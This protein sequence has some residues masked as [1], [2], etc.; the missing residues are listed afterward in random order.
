MSSVKEALASQIRIDKTHLWLDSKTEVCWIKGSK[1][2]KQFV[3]NRVNEI[4]SLTEESMWNHCPGIENRADVGCRGESAAKLKSNVLW[5]KGPSWLS[6]PMRNWHSSEECSETIAEECCVEMKK[7]QA[8]EAVREAVLLTTNGIPNM[9]TI[10]PI[11]DFSS[12]DKLFRI[13]ALVLPFVK[14]LKIKAKLL[15]IGTVYLGDVTAEELGNAEMKWL[16]SV[17]NELKSQA[18]YSQLELDFGLYEDSS[19]QFVKRTLASCTVCRR[20]EGKSYRVPPQ[21]DLPEFRLS[22]KPAFTY[23]GIDYA[24]PLYIKVSGQSAL[25]KV[26]VLLFTCCSVRS[27]H[28]EL[29]TDLSVDVFIRCLRRFAARRGLPELIISDNAKTFK[30]AD[31]ILSKLFSYP[32]VKKFLA[33]KRI[34]WRFDVDKAPLWG[35]FFERLIHN[36]KRCLRK[37]LRNAKLNY[38]ELH[39]ALVEVEGTLNSR[40]EP[41]TPSHLMY[42]R[43]I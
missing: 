2:W 41:L 21:S 34:D 37:T 38:D 36:T 13:T 5:W 29:A 9:D 18:N 20:Y 22:Q 27:V 19:G 31:K 32:R 1:E 42:G 14:N 40:E 33:S 35:G 43:R 6:K 28:L 16:R 39:T 30:A 8:I 26:Y 17:Q 11:T 4:L 24:G 10:I 7:G 23:V 12:C 25:Q 15:K 3:Q